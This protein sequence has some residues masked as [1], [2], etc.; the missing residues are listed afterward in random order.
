MA[1]KKQIE[2]AAQAVH[3]FELEHGFITR[4]WRGVQAE[5]EYY[6]MARVALTASEKLSG[7]NLGTGSESATGLGQ[8]VKPLPARN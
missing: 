4:E 2:V 5:T 1:T 7:L 3:K 8:Y 6:E